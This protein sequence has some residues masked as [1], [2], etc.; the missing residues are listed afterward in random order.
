MIRLRLPISK[1]IALRAMALDFVVAM[2]SSQPFTPI[3]EVAGRLGLCEE[4]LA[5]DDIRRFSDALRTLGNSLIADSGCSQRLRIEIGDGAAPF[6]FFIAI[7][8]ALPGA[9]VRVYPSL[10]LGR[11]L[12]TPLISALKTLGAGIRPVYSESPASSLPCQAERKGGILEY[13]DVDGKRLKGGR[14]EIDGSVSSQYASA[15]LIAS[16]LMDEPLDVTFAGGA[17]CAS[18]P[19]LDMTQRMLEASEA[20]VDPYS[21]I[22]YD[23]SAASYFY[24]WALLHP[25]MAVAL[26]PLKPSGESLQG[27][28]TVADIFAGVGVVT[29]FFQD[30][31]VILK[32]PDRGEAYICPEETKEQ[33]V[34]FTDTPDLVPAVA[35]AFCEAGIPFMFTGVGN[36]VHK[37]SDRLHLICRELSALGHDIR[38]INLPE[39]EPGKDREG[40]AAPAIKFTPS[41]RSGKAGEDQNNVEDQNNIETQPKAA[42]R[43]NAHSDHRLAMAFAPLCRK[44]VELDGKEAVVKSFPSFWEEFRK[45]NKD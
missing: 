13:V 45:L 40:A 43:L 32:E 30:S 41:E 3:H 33:V 2:R 7:A 31:T 19:Y 8:A 23:W 42:I 34:D 14:I 15:L 39:E 10:Q 35:A 22:E 9:K 25:G 1:S 29:N 4:H 28:A 11:R 6:R 37:E 44:G 21:M 38:V 26:P 24:E 5:A 12:H 18:K 17:K 20:G 16:P 36:L 27:D